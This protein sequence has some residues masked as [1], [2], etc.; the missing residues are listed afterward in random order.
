[1]QKRPEKH[2]IIILE[3]KPALPVSDGGVVMH[4]SCLNFLCNVSRTAVDCDHGRVEFVHSTVVVEPGYGLV[5]AVSG[6]AQWYSRRVPVTPSG[7]RQKYLVCF[8]RDQ[9]V[10]NAGIRLVLVDLQE[11]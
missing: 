6:D 8:L 11:E 7:A 1:M 9:A 2:Q 3:I 4:G 5:C 10:V